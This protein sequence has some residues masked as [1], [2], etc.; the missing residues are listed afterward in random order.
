M[1]ILWRS[2]RLVSYLSLDFYEFSFISYLVNA[3]I[4]WV[5]LVIFFV[6]LQIE[7]QLQQQTTRCQTKML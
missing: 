2:S 4:Y 7:Q 1:N 3:D 6:I 5:C